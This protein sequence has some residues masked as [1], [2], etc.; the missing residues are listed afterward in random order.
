MRKKVLN[1]FKQRNNNRHKNKTERK[2]LKE[3]IGQLI[4]IHEKESK[5]RQDCENEWRER[6]DRSE[7][8]C[9]TTA[10]S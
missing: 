2:K 4:L 7:K 8:D 1:R 9:E 5:K 6:E 3:K 10:K